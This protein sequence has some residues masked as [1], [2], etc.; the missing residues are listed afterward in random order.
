M[1][2]KHFISILLGLL[3]LSPFMLL[4]QEENGDQ[5]DMN[6]DVTFIGDLELFIRDANK[7]N[8]VPQTV[9]ELNELPPI[10][11]SLIPNK[12]NA[13]IAVSPIDAARVNVEEKIKK[14]YRGFIRGGFGLYTTPLLELSYTEGRSRNG[15]YGVS[16]RHISTQGNVAVDDSIPDSFSNNSVH[17]WGKKF[18]KRHALTGDFTFERE[19]FNYY[20]FLPDSFPMVGEDAIDQRFNLIEGSAGLVSYFRDSTDLNYDIGLKYYNFSDQNNGR[21]NNIDLRGLF[22]K[23][24]NSEIY[25]LNVGLN[26]NHFR[27]NYLSDNIEGTQ[28]NAIL[29]IEPSAFTK[30]GNL[31]VTV[32][33]SLML[34]GT[35]DQPVHFYPLAEASYG[36][37]NDILVPYAGI[38]GEVVRQSYRDLTDINPFLLTD[39]ELRS[40]NNSLEAYGGVRGRISSNASFNAHIKSN[41]YEQFAYFINDT[42]FSAANQF[43]VVYDKLGVIN[44]GGELSMQG[45]EKFSLYVRGDYFIYNTREQDEAWHQPESRFSLGG[46]YN[47]QDKLIFRGEVYQVGKRKA[48]SNGPT[49]D[50]ELQEDDTYI[51]ELK[52]YLDA[53]LEAEYRYTKRLSVFARMNNFLASKYAV[54]NNYNLQRFNAMMGATFAF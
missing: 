31:Q 47:I 27:F 46:V 6:M 15:T 33:M 3:F 24:V 17:L 13:E 49:I 21:E 54:W 9:E 18:I 12:M 37:F 42:S 20:G 39:P 8:D 2:N 35:G 40:M 38:R 34:D 1:T 19:A 5:E 51:T 11:Y 30:R 22:K 14:L 32:G 36:L 23:Q 52:G 26:Y 43:S 16:A 53:N 41:N 4:A 25:R 45:N 48:L 10:R 7:I 29:R 28:D 50:G 44:I